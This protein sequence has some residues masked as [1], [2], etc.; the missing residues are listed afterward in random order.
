MKNSAK[1]Q[2]GFV[3]AILLPPAGLPL[4]SAEI[5]AARLPPPAGVPVDFE[6]DIKPIFEQSCFRCH[7]PER[8][9]SRFRLDNRESA[10]KG[11][12]NNKDDI[13]PGDSAQSKLIHYVTR[14]VED[15]EMPPSGKGEPL[16]SEQIGLLRK[17]VDD[18]ARWPPGAE[19]IKRETQFSITPMAQW[20]TVGGNE[21]KFREHWGQKKG[22]TA[23]YDRFEMIEPVG[24]DTELKVEGRAL[25]PQEDYRIGLTLTRPDVGFVRAGY[26]TYR[27]Y[28]SDTGGFYPPLNQPALSLGRDLHEDFGKAWFDVGLARP[29]WP[30]LVLGYEYQ[31]R[32]GDESTLQWGPVGTNSIAPAYKQVDESAHILKLDASHEFSGVLLEEM[33]RG[34]FYNLSTRQNAFSS[35]GSPTLMPISQVDESYKH[36]VG[37]NALSLEKQVFD[38]LLLSGG[39]LYR[40]LDGDGALSQAIGFAASPRIVLSQQTHVVNA[41]AQLGPWNGLSGFGGVQLEW[42][43]Q[44]GN[45]EIDSDLDF[46]TASTIATGTVFSDLDK[47]TRDE[48][49]GLRYTR[50]P[51]TVLFAEARWQQEDLDQFEDEMD[52]AAGA[53]IF[54]RDTDASSELKE[55]RAGFTL[56]PWA[57]ISLSSHYKH[58]I[59]DTDYDHVTDTNATPSGSSFIFSGNGYS[60]FIRNRRLETDEIEAKLAWR[61]NRWLKTTLTYQL[62]ATDY[63]T[64]TD[65]AVGL[66]SSN[67]VVSASPGG[68][69]FAGNY[70]AQVYSFNAALTPGRRFY[71]SGTF[72]YRDTRLATSSDFDPVVVPYRGKVYSVLGNMSYALNDKTD[73]RVNYAFSRA[74]YRQQNDAAGL[75][76]GIVYRR[77]GATASLTRRLLKNMSGTVQYGFFYYTE[78]TSGGANNYKAHAVLATI[79]IRLP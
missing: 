43:R 8:P 64:T 46:D 27:K 34:E 9:K 66:D 7:G 49:I 69:F 25:F 79:S 61:L 1:I 35:S 59:R 42:T 68:Q 37:A 78:P 2:C 28:F 22:F 19:T 29:D 38:W 40:K 72:S 71:I 24:K 50:I 11:G 45:G 3:L 65:A 21:Q 54:A 74:D 41:N 56:S 18:G 44:K 58:R 10:L 16:T 76:Q 60:A 55:A 53:G 23:G 4:R 77:H 31:S 75:P 63:H 70:D 36:F 15:L 52:S 73:L 6:R 12:E 13:V 67:N 17:W 26:D 5:D 51:F 57:N 62:T 48:E 20:I 32:K 47:F 39:Y 14:L 33:F 30:K